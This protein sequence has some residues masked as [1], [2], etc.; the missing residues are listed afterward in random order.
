MRGLFK[1]LRP[2]RAVIVL[3]VTLIFI[4]CLCN[5]Y[6][7]ILMEKIVDNGVIRGNV[8]YIWKMG[9]WML[10]GS[11]GAVVFSI[12]AGLLSS[13]TAASF[14]RVVR[15][16]VFTHVEQFSLHEFDQ[17]GTSSLITRATNDITQ[18]QQLVNMMLRMMIMAPLN[19]VGGILMAVYTDGKLSLI[20]VVIMPL[21]A[22]TIYFVYGRGTS[23]FKAMQV[24]IDKLNRV[25]RENLT[26]IRVIR[27]FNRYP[28]EQARFEA[29]NFDLTDTTTRVQKIM[30]ALMPMLML[31]INGST[32][33]IIWF[34]GLRINAGT[35]QV[36]ALIAFT[37]YVMQLLMSVMMVSM[38]FFMIPRA[39]AS[40]ARINE[41]LKKEPEIVDPVTPRPAHAQRGVLTFHDVT[42][43][44]PG[45]E[46]PALSG[47]SFIARPGEVTAII[48]GTGAGKSTL[49]SLIPR[50]YDVDKGRITLDGVDLRELTQADLRAKI[51]YVPQ[52]AVLFTGSVTQNI[53]YGKADATDEEV[54]RAADIAQATDFILE[55][56]DGFQ[57]V[58]EQG[59]RNV[60]GGQKQR[61]SIARAIVRGP[62][63]YIF[64]DSFSALDFRTDAKLRAALRAEVTDATVLIVAQRVTTI[65]DADH[66]IVLDQGEI[67]GQGTHR[68][69]LESCTVYREIVASQLSEEE[70]A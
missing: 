14:G 22:A 28:Y 23:L 59:G 58:I 25:I 35:M 2:Y 42:F 66:I 41:V 63:I 6:L 62:D 19:C 50:F 65:M 34:G 4:Q 52:Q 44:Y 31:I 54:L 24:K 46:Q 48:G 15:E 5:L 1:Y 40:A 60:S 16:E 67:V 30:A 43:S 64:D 12:T 33:A 32:I 56:K 27:S 13:R 61:L 51:G 70:I 45:A 11:I 53:R 10:L 38:M 20:I 37:Q 9:G 26:G 3:I 55:M 8:P 36:G 17:F 68:Q 47:I 21:L 7:P 39:V 29:A 18:V 49:V 57:S 69:L